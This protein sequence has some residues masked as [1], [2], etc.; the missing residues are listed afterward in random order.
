MHKRLRFIFIVGIVMLSA[1]VQSE[2]IN[3]VRYKLVKPAQPLADPR[4]IEV[5]EFFW[6]GCPHCY[7]LEPALKQW[8]QSQPYAINFIRIPV[9]FNGLASKHAR[10]YFTAEILGVA[11]ELH[12]DFFDAIQNKNKRLGNEDQLAK[13]FSERGI[14]EQIFRENY[15]SFAV[16][17]KVRKAKSMAP[18]YGI[19]SVPTIIVNGKYK[20]NAV[21][22]KGQ[23][24]LIAV[25]EE[26]V[27]TERK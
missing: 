5:I 8:L 14:N 19:R 17:A 9:F 20:T 22:A 21:L 15:N 18:R 16:D 23:K 11:E 4:K 1:P 25:I 2:A 26:L 3:G 10:A 6:Y 27:A 12:D 24:N 7:F 13:F